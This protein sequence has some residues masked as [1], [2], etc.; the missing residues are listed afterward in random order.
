MFAT[1][2]EV[3][4]FNK[5]KMCTRPFKHSPGE[6][7]IVHDVETSQDSGVRMA[8]QGAG[9]LAGATSSPMPRSN[10]RKSF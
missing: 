6:F 2:E 5:P 9:R 4:L 10:P 1:D 8:A 7:S 3:V